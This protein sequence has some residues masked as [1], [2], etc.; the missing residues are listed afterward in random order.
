MLDPHQ[1]S[2]IAHTVT[3]FGVK[4]MKQMQEGRTFQ[5]LFFAV[6]KTTIFYQGYG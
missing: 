3:V 2:V 1:L 6:E 5:L 4:K